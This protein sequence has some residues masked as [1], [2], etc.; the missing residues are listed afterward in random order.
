[1]QLAEAND[2]VCKVKCAMEFYLKVI[3][4]SRCRLKLMTLC[5]IVA[6]KRVTIDYP[7]LEPGIKF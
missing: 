3:N 7:Y 1:M 4:W 6:K 5:T 2:E